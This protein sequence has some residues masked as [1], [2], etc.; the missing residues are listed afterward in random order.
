MVVLILMLVSLQKKDYKKE[1]KR[2]LKESKKNWQH[3]QSK[4]L[5]II[6][7]PNR[8]STTSYIQVLKE[9]KDLTKQSS[10]TSQ[11]SI[12]LTKLQFISHSTSNNKQYLNS[13]NLRWVIDLMV[14]NFQLMIDLLNFL[15]A[16]APKWAVCH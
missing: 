6:N 13:R 5:A 12:N 9:L 1:K 11:L 4:H 16:L 3:I 14:P 10:I 7:T 8:C 2:K 15:K